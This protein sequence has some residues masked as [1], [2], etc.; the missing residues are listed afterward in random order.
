MQ[1]SPSTLARHQLNRLLGVE[2]F[3]TDFTSTHAGGGSNTNVAKVSD[4][5]GEQPDAPAPP[6][7]DREG[8][9]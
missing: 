6:A 9:R 4:L 7:G 2:S 1:P 5:T 3:S 8:G